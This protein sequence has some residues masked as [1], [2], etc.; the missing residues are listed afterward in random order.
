MW[1]GPFYRVQR[2]GYEICFVPGAGEDLDEVCNVDLW[3]TFADGNRW[4]GTVFTLDEVQR[5][6]DRW[7]GTGAQWSGWLRSGETRSVV[8]VRVQRPAR[9]PL[10]GWPVAVQTSFVSAYLGRSRREPDPNPPR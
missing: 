4:S 1:D 8:R 5:L 6:M 2:D 7:K 10:T 3:V 9:V